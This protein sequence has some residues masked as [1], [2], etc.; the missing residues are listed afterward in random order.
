MQKIIFPINH[1]VSIH[2]NNVTVS[3]K[4]SSTTF[5]R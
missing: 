3:T 2:Q 1:V 5:N 4:L